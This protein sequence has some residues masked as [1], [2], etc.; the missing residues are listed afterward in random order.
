MIYSLSNSGNSDD[1]EWPSGSCT[2]CRPFK[3]WF[4][5]E[6][7][8][9]QQDFNWN[10]TLCGPSVVAGLLVHNKSIISHTSIISDKQ[11]DVSESPVTNEYDLSISRE[12]RLF[13]NCRRWRRY[14]EW[15]REYRSMWRR[16]SASTVLFWQLRRAMT[17]SEVYYFSY[18]FISMF[19]SMAQ[20]PSS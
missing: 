17:V 14:A 11:C 8:N 10:S 20:Q 5:A 12:R 1:L 13:C 3:M 18:F 9:S 15:S 4:F 2:Y 7:C 16:W 19:S 6:L